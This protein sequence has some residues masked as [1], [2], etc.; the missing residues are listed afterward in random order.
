MGCGLSSWPLEDKVSTEYPSYESLK[1]DRPADGVLRVTL[2]RGKV[3]AM[4]FALHHD[5]AQIWRLIDRDPE[6][7]VVVVT[8]EGR[9]FSAGG[10][11]GTDG[12][13]MKDYDF[14]ISMVK[15]AR[16]LV[17]N[18]MSCSK[19]IVSAINGP[20][21]GG[22]LVVA[23]MADISIAAKSAKLVDGHARLGVAAG[24]HA[25]I[26][27]PILC[28]MAKAKYY[29]MTCDSITGEEAERIGLVSMAVEDDQ[30]MARALSV[31][32]RLAKG[33]PNALRWTKMTLN[34]WLRQAWPIFEASMAYEA[35]GFLGPDA[36]EGMA[37]HLEK[38]D[39]RFT[40]YS[41]L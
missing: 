14:M 32:E 12:R 21:A 33:S 6:V 1:L 10:D 13:I 2:S 34:G 31:A 19:P 40:R 17:E 24:D 15:D 35:L 36:R 22:G 9:C 37:A 23:L 39:P 41:P 38:R 7:N 5:I 25:S 16:E 30:L 26:I 27:W 28:G 29:L 4:D 3:N 8:G 20:A 11:F 18:M